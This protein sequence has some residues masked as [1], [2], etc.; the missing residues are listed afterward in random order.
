[1]RGHGASRNVDTRRPRWRVSPHRVDI[2]RASSDPALIKPSTPMPITQHHTA[3]ESCRLI[4][5]LL[6]MPISLTKP[7]GRTTV[8]RGPMRVPPR[9]VSQPL[10]QDHMRTVIYLA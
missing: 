4:L 6:V 5:D 8:S 7:L 2:G 1:M 10:L 9:C 3:I